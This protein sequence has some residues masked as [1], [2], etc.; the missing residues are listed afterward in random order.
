MHIHHLTV[1][2]SIAMWSENFFRMPHTKGGLLTLGSLLKLDNLCTTRLKNKILLAILAELC[3]PQNNPSNQC[4]LI[5][6]PC[7]S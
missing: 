1:L 3:I 2:S 7:S 6:M 5:F 4:L